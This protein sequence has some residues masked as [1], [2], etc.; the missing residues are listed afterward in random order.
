MGRLKGCPKGRMI[1]IGDLEGGAEEEEEGVDG[2]L[3]ILMSAL[4]QSLR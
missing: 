4:D 3:L 2:G 1:T